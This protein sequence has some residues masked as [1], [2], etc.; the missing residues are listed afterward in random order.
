[1]N[2]RKGRFFTGLVSCFFSFMFCLNIN[3]YV[4]AKDA[5][6]TV[7][8]TNDSHGNVQHEAYLKALADTKKQNGE[9]VLILAA[10]DLFHGRLI[11]SLSKGTSI[12]KIMNEVGYDYI[13]PGNHDFNYN[14]SG[15]QDLDSISNCKVLAANIIN[16]TDNAY[17]FA[18]YD[19]K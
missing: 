11:A 18:P 9:N 6:F 13:A 3:S 8:H 16:K 19:I 2:K 5:A 4:L 15:L 7:L 17:V 14:L 10:G 12:A 1:M